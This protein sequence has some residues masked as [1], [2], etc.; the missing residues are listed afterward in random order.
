MLQEGIYLDSFYETSDKAAIN[1][2]WSIP[3]NLTE[4]FP[5]VFAAHPSKIG[6]CHTARA[7]SS[8]KHC[9]TREW[10]TSGGVCL[11]SMTMDSM[12]WVLKLVRKAA[13][14]GILLGGYGRGWRKLIERTFEDSVML[15]GEHMEA[16]D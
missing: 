2:Q 5:P 16:W 11:E 9:G 13:L 12:P 14:V 10:S 1:Q 6:L 3:V 7:R 4:N 8:L 15:Q